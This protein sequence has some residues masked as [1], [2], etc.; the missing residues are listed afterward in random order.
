MDHSEWLDRQILSFPNV[1]ESF[2]CFE[3]EE[4]DKIKGLSSMIGKW[5][6]LQLNVLECN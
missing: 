2:I 4:E 6:T 5:K 1:L 3:F